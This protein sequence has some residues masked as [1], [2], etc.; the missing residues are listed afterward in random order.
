[1]IPW[2]VRGH[3][4]KW[5]KIDGV[6]AKAAV[7]TGVSGKVFVVVGFS[8][9]LTVAG[10]AQFFSGTSTALTGAADV[11]LGVP[12][13]DVSVVGCFATASGADLQLECTTGTGNGYVAYCEVDG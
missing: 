5:A 8:V 12:W 2:T 1:M 4:V 9:S 10:K 3:E 11:G 13:S 7:I 6:L